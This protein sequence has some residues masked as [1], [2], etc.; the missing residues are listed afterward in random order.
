MRRGLGGVVVE[1]IDKEPSGVAGVQRTRMR[2]RMRMKRE[3]CVH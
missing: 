1:A 3:V 2:T